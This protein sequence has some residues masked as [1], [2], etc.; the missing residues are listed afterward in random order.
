MSGRS[1]A[2]TPPRSP[3]RTASRGSLD[4]EVEVPREAWAPIPPPDRRDVP[5]P[6]VVWVGSVLREELA[7]RAPVPG[8]S[9]SVPVRVVSLGV[10]A[11]VTRPG[12]P[13]VRMVRLDAHHRLVVGGDV[14]Q[15]ELS[16]PALD[17]LGRGRLQ[18]G[19][20]PAPSGPWE[21]AAMLA[22]E[23]E[24][25]RLLAEL[26]SVMLRA[27]GGSLVAVRGIIPS[28]LHGPRVIGWAPA[29][30][31]AALPAPMVRIGKQLHA[32]DRTP[33]YR[34]LN[35]DTERLGWLLGAAPP[36]ATANKLAHVVNVE[37]RGSSVEEALQLAE[38]SPHALLRGEGQHGW[39]NPTA[40]LAR[41]LR[42]SL[43]DVTRCRLRLGEALQ[44]HGLTFEP[45]GWR[46]ATP[47]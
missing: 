43:G 32:G 14:P 23:R 25:R 6:S 16:L 19:V 34:P 1:L 44:V 24:R 4:L 21:R 17:R 36:L 30:R 12:R 31:H 2:Q 26:A 11:A 15:P 47:V 42:L 37:V 13:G 45:A 27:H 20:L 5:W 9:E 40:E 46:S 39:R 22:V 18:L 8:T 35:A 33:L 38:D 3:S 28:A 29:G 10:G 41:Q 7:G